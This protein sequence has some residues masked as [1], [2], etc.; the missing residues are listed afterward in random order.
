MFGRPEQ[1]IKSQI[2]KVRSLPYVNESDLTSLINFANKVSNMTTFLE[3]VDGTYHLA[4]PLLLSELLS[5]LPLSRRLQWADKCLISNRMPTIKDFA[6]WLSDLRKVVNMVTDS[7]PLSNELQENKKFLCLT[8]DHRKCR[9]CSNECKSLAVCKE[10][11]SLPL[12]LRW[13]KVMSFKVCF[14]CLKFGHQANKC[15]IKRKCEINDCNRFHH[16][17][18]H[19]HILPQ[20]SN[21]SDCGTS[22]SPA[23]N[24]FVEVNSVLFQVIPV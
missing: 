3:S 23:R 10:F 14:S 1:L 6:Q 24:C 11:S 19:K 20:S 2:H 8:V 9:L 22:P 18:L 17:L 5:K 16:N 13:Q 21:V 15:Y 4:N 12:D 7:L